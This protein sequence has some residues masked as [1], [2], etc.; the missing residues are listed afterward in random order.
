[1]SDL[2]TP[3]AVRLRRPSW[4]DAR[5]LVGVALILG[6]A[7]IGSVVVAGADDRVPM[8]AAATTLVAGEPVK[9]DQLVRV[10][11]QLG[12][13]AGTYLSAAAGVPD[14]A[15]A[16]RNVRPGELVPREALGSPE[17]AT[18]QPLVLTVDATST[19]ALV[20]GSVV[21]V[22]VNPPGE[23]GD[24]GSAGSSDYAGAELAISRAPVLDLPTGGRGLGGGSAASRA[25][26]V[27]I[28]SDEVKALIDQVDGG[29]RIT[30]VPVAG[31]PRAGS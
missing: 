12:D 13:S 23:G 3:K 26:L 18:Q 2:P 15:V 20:V 16:L 30:L 6:A 8:Y 19:A 4:R 21:D 9:E 31:S 28:P 7:A 25:V 17:D 24:G 11:V 10:D 14:D 22:Y 1:M 29:A 27:M 5:L